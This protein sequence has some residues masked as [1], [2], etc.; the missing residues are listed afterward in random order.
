MTHEPGVTKLLPLQSAVRQTLGSNLDP[1]TPARLFLFSATAMRVFGRMCHE[2][3]W[4]CAVVCRGVPGAVQRP[5]LLRRRVLPLPGR[6]EGGGV[7]AAGQWVLGRGLQ[8]PWG[9]R[10]GRPLLLP[11]GLDRPRLRAEWVHK[12]D[13]FKPNMPNQISQAK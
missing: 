1:V 4:C 12:M 3:W 11:P 6:L 8:R 10:G 2:C 9:L 7:W 13:Q 5:R